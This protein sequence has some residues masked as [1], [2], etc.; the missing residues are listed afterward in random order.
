[1]AGSR[2]R[3]ATLHREILFPKPTKPKGNGGCDNRE[4]SIVP[5][6]RFYSQ[7]CFCLFWAVLGLEFR[8]S[9]L[10]GRGSTPGAT[11][12]ALFVKGFFF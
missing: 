10:P 7:R 12:P 3:W 5:V 1:M 11:P 2:P 9:Y 4:D 6:I 8:D